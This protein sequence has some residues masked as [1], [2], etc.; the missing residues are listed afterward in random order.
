MI[1]NGPSLPP[2]RIYLFMY[3]FIYLLIF[4]ISAKIHT[5]QSGLF[6]HIVFIFGPPCVSKADNPDFQT[7]FIV[8]CYI[9]TFLKTGPLRLIR[10]NF[11][12][13]QRLLIIFGTERLYSILNLLS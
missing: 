8:Q 4:S 7:R 6:K 2:L 9:Y 1:K 10:H 5:N 13:S 11:S 12:N 3:S